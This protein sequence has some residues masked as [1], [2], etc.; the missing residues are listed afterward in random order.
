MKKLI[1]IADWVADTLTCQEV[2]T[3]IEGY[4]K[5]SDNASVSFVS[6]T[7]STIHTAYL[8]AQLVETEARYGRPLETLLF[9]NTDPR[10][11]SSTAVEKAH[12]AP[13]VIA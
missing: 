12:G 13:L 11:Q 4:L 3:S 5:N 2:R 7:P 9:Q 6:S 1:T 8:L 10:I